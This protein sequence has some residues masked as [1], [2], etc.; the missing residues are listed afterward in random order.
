M[1]RSVIL[2]APLAAL[3]FVAV[4]LAVDT[5]GDGWDDP[6]EHYINTLQ[7]D[8]C[9]T[10]GIFPSWPPDMN[11]DSFVDITDIA[12]TGQYFG[13]AVSPSAPARYDVAPINNW[14]GFV[15]ILDIGIVGSYFGDS[16][17]P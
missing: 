4:A 11:V 16:C 15:D 9:T 2:L 7:D 12:R 13:K 5:D 3:A 8:D 1:F 10:G 14:D 6:H 17:T